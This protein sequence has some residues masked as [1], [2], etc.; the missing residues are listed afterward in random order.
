VSQ[1]EEDG[2]AKYMFADRT[3]DRQSDYVS[4][5][6]KAPEIEKGVFH[7]VKKGRY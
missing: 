5:P 4:Q 3:Q 7:K 6:E 1:A 2:K